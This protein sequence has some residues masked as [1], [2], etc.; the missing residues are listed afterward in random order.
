MAECTL[1]L[2]IVQAVFVEDCLLCNNS[3]HETGRSLAEQ[4]HCKQSKDKYYSI[5]FWTGMRYVCNGR[6]IGL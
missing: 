6:S 1:I 4:C 5:V 3:G 2:L